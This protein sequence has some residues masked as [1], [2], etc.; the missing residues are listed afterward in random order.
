MHLALDHQIAYRYQYLTLWVYDHHFFSP[1]SSCAFLDTLLV[2]MG[3]VRTY[4][5]IIRSDRNFNSNHRC[6]TACFSIVESL[7]H[8]PV[9][10]MRD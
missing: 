10:T 5:G 4:V 3:C 8:L 1:N 2:S 7:A 6:S 9:S